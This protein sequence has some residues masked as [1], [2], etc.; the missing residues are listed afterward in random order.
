VSPPAGTV[1][2]LQNRIQRARQAEQAG[3]D[4]SLEL[5][6]GGATVRGQTDGRYRDVPKLLL[7]L[8]LRADLAACL[9][10]GPR[11]RLALL[12]QR[13]DHVH[14]VKVDVRI[15][16]R[17]PLGPCPLDGDRVVPRGQE[18]ALPHG[19]LVEGG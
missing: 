4:F 8:A 7:R 2:R 6:L 16:R 3:V 12:P 13:A 11:N 19:L 10:R 5:P 17:R 9:I 15:R 1:G 14:R 18:A